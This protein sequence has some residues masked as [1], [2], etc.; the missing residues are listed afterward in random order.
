[1]SKL[2][3]KTSYERLGTENP[4]TLYHITIVDSKGFAVGRTQLR[5]RNSANPEALVVRIRHVVSDLLDRTQADSA[6][7][8]VQRILV[9][10]KTT[11]LSRL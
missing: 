5:L 8:Q 10:S 2:Q 1:M 11:T 4:S 9:L 3:V 7:M 6:P